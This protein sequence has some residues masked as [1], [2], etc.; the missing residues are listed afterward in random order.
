MR[1]KPGDYVCV[2]IIIPFLHSPWGWFINT[3]IRKF[4][5]SEYSHAFIVI[6]D[7]GT[8][9][10]ARPKGIGYGNISQYEGMPM[11]GSNTIL[12]D[13]QRADIISAAKKYIGTPYGFMDILYIGLHTMGFTWTWLLNKVRRLKTM[14]CSQYCSQA[15]DDAGVLSWRCGRKY[16]QEVTPA[17]LD[18]LAMQQ[19]PGLHRHERKDLGAQA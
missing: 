18:I 11:Q 15:G 14:I 4:T 17:D 6:D 5:K 12:T 3:L 9:L 8:I 10:E 1:F 7:H 2:D 19:R 13:E 16:A